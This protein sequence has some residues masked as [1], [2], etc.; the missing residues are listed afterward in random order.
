MP[1]ADFLTSRDPEAKTLSSGQAIDKILRDDETH[2]LTRAVMRVAVFVLL[3]AGW[4]LNHLAEW[5]VVALGAIA[6][7]GIA[8]AIGLEGGWRVGSAIA[9]AAAALAADI[10]WAARSRRARTEAAKA[11]SP[12]AETERPDLQP[13]LRVSVGA[14]LVRLLDKAHAA[15]LIPPGSKIEFVSDED[16]TEEELRDAVLLDDDED[17]DA[18]S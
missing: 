16:L 2:W 15:G 6:G 3:L 17:E 1:G 14:P 13:A 8:R 4:M 10:L 5:V 9:G 18:Q 11:S 12:T 7:V